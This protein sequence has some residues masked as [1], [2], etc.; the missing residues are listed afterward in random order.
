M[1]PTD[2]DSGVGQKDC[3]ETTPCSIGKS[4]N[5]AVCNGRQRRGLREGSGRVRGGTKRPFPNIKDIVSE[6]GLSPHRQKGQRKYRWRRTAGL[7]R[8]GSG[9]P[10]GYP[11]P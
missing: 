1:A 9:H 10:E 8:E 6:R 2:Q 5:R 4:K 3:R 11:G 7:A